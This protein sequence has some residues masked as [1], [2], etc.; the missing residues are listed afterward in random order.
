MV[1]NWVVI[2]NNFALLIRY[3]YFFIITLL[4]ALVFDD[5]V[6][7]DEMNIETNIFKGAYLFLIL[8]LLFYLFWLMFVVFRFFYRGFRNTYKDNNFVSSMV[9]IIV[10]KFN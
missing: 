2:K 4:A 1:T 6:K 5:A 7:Y 9:L 3:S 8:L 10:Y